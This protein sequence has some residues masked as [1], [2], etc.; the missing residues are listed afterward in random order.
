MVEV[1]SN[2]ILIDKFLDTGI[3][4]VS[5]GSNDL[6]QLIFGVG[7]DNPALANIFDEIYKDDSQVEDDGSGISD[8]KAESL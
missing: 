3:D 6:T 1:P 7:R 4:G 8:V 5:I 2:V